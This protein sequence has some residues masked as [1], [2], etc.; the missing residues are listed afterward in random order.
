VVVPIIL[1]D[2]HS[3]C[4]K[5]HV[6]SVQDVRKPS[7]LLLVELC[8][9]AMSVINIRSLYDTRKP[10]LKCVLNHRLYLTADVAINQIGHVG[11]VKMVKK[12]KSRY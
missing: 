6:R 10:A 7:F 9:P 8:Q 4:V 12:N 11:Q 1:P 5:L 3:K 2:K